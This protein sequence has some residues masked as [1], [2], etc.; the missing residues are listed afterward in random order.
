M[1]FP[2]LPT[3]DEVVAPFRQGAERGAARRGTLS[4]LGARDVLPE[5]MGVGVLILPIAPPV[6]DDC[7]GVRDRHNDKRCFFTPRLHRAF[8]LRAARRGDAAA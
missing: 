8:R 5:S 7:H 6:I 3:V 1:S 2:T 4:P